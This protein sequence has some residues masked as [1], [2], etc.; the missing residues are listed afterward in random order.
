MENEESNRNL[1][2]FVK[3]TAKNHKSYNN[4]LYLVN[5]YKQAS[6]NSTCLT[7]FYSFSGQKVYKLKTC[8]QFPHDYIVLCKKKQ[9]LYLVFLVIEIL[10]IVFLLT[11][12]YCAWKCREYIQVL[13]LIVL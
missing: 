12:I 9:K 4:I 11:I 6:S 8:E 2:K 13:F 7:F 5:S 1:M 10:I 3:C